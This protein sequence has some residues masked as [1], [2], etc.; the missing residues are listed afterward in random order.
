MN[1]PWYSILSLNKSASGEIHFQ[2]TAAASSPWFDGHFP[3]EP[4]LPGIAQISIVWDTIK[5]HCGNSADAAITDVKRLRFRQII[6]PDEVMSVTI[7]PDG[8]KAGSYSF[9]ITVRGDLAC[10]GLIVTV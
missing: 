3:G 10:N 2:A 4:I 9:K 8:K 1:D 6:R 5:A 7:V